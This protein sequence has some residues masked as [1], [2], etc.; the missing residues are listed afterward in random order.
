MFREDAVLCFDSAVICAFLDCDVFGVKLTMWL[1]SAAA[2]ARDWIVNTAAPLWWERG[3]DPSGGFVERIGLGGDAL[4]ETRR[5]RVSARQVYAFAVAA[6]LGWSGPVERA[7]AQGLAFLRGPGSTGS[8]GIAARIAVDGTILDAGPD[9]YDQAFWMLA[10]AEAQRISGDPDLEAEA[11]RA[12]DLIERDLRHPVVGYEER[13][14]R[15]LPLRANPH[16]HLL[17]VAI[18]WMSVGTSPRWRGLGRKVVAMCRDRFRDPETGA[19]LEV[20]DGDWQPLP[21]ADGDSVEPGHLFEWT[22]LLWRWQALSGEPTAAMALR[23]AEIARRHGVDRDRNVAV[24]EIGRDF[25][26]KR[27]TARAWPQTERLKAG[28]ACR[29]W[30]APGSAARSEAEAEILSAW[31]AIERY[32]D[33]AVPGLWRDRMREDG[34]FVE[35]PAP[36]STFYH[37]ACAAAELAAA[38]ELVTAAE[39]VKATGHGAAAELAAAVRAAEPVTVP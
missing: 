12:L 17:E 28:I 15:H 26:I 35:E 23:F 24:D 6:R 14:P 22:W 32:L 20:F 7:M 36:A 37:F 21:G 9:L 11:L 3:L 38:A 4:R 13:R 33:V 34:R 8:G 30:A 10:L 29:D 25:R 27:A 31:A 5:V 1:E 2:K 16:M 19:L 39:L 18:A